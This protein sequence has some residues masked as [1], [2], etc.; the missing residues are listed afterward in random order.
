MVLTYDPLTHDYRA[1]T[2]LNC[3][4]IRI[5]DVDNIYTF[6]FKQVETYSNSYFI[7]VTKVRMVINFY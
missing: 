6:M 3:S 4:V 7:T 2:V 1:V 5:L